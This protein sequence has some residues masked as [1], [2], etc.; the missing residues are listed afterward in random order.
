[1]SVGERLAAIADADARQEA[2]TAW[3]REHGF[4]VAD[5]D[6]APVSE[7]QQEPRASKWDIKRWVA[8]R[9]AAR[10]SKPARQADMDRLEA[11]LKGEDSHLKGVDETLAYMS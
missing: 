11:E 6:A 9:K 10:E 2:V 3:R 1:M 5:E 8:D 4:A 7:P